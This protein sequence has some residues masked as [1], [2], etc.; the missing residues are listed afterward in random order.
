MG[1]ARPVSQASC[2]EGVTCGGRPERFAR[3][4]HS[5]RT[6]APRG[7]PCGAQRSAVAAHQLAQVAASSSLPAGATLTHRRRRVAPIPPL[8]MGQWHSPC[9]CCR[10]AHLVA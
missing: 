7:R 3:V 8:A 6:A 5:R 1:A 10:D 4:Q 9:P 2:P